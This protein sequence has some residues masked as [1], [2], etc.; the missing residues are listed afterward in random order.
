MS[1]VDLE[2]IVIAY[3]PPVTYYHPA[4]GRKY[5]VTHDDQ[6]GIITV[7]IGNHYDPSQINPLMRDEVLAEWKSVQ[8]Q[9]ILLVTVHVSDGEFD[10]NHAKIRFMIFQQELPLALQAI[11]HA[12]TPFLGY[13][14]WLL[15]SPIY[16]KFN[17]TYPEYNQTIKYGTPRQYL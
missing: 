16:V 1:I 15:N 8:G 14:P 2:K 4:E 6:S 7:L 9:Y 13:F 17:S 12:D 3:I 10:A 11:M 5:T